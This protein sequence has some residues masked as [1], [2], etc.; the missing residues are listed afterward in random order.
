MRYPATAMLKGNVAVNHWGT[1]MQLYKGAYMGWPDKDG[2]SSGVIPFGKI[3]IPNELVEMFIQQTAGYHLASMARAMFEHQEHIL[4]DGTL[5]RELSEDDRKMW[6]QTA[7]FGILS[8]KELYNGIDGEG[9]TKEVTEVVILDENRPGCETIEI[10]GSLGYEDERLFVT[11]SLNDGLRVEI[12]NDGD[13]SS[14]QITD[15]KTAILIAAKLISWGE[16]IAEP[17]MVKPK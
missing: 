4:Q 3:K 11:N 6:E 13:A 10:Q 7:L 9:A 1:N 8:L 2:K 5:W 17:P 14:F 16:R 12:Q 15:R